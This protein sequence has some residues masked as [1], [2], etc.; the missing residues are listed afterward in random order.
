MEYFE[1][2][3][4]DGTKLGKVKERKQVHK[5]G[6]LH[7]GAH[8]WV[9]RRKE[10]DID[11][12]NMTYEVLLQKRKMDKDSFPGCYD[13]SCAGHMTK[14]ETFLTTAL[15]ELEEE[16]RIQAK[17]EDLTFLFDQRVEGKYQFHGQFFW[18]REVNFVYL[19][20]M[21]VSLDTLSYQKEE[22]EELVW[23]ELDKLVWEVRNQ[24]PQYCIGV[25][26]M[27]RIYAYLKEKPERVAIG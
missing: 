23:L 4:E 2:L 13:V 12:E 1:L 19:L 27:E 26:E 9:V 17:E 21:D 22:I 7:G 16:L 11:T 18:N 3:Q 14:G 6:D 8:V 5:E 24:N 25:K 10:H 20:G 15:R